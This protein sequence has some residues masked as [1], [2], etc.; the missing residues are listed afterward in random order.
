VCRRALGQEQDAEDAFQTTFLALARSAGSVRRQGAL[1]AWLYGV[2]HR[3]A[4]NAQRSLAR[5]RQKEQQ[6]ARTE[7]SPPPE[8]LSWREVQALLDEEVQA[9]PEIY[10]RVFVLCSLLGQTR[11]EAARQLGL[12][13]GTVASRLGK[14]RALL[15]RRLAR[16]GVSL[17]TLM[18]ALDVAQGA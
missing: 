17:S 18:A 7:A 13:E 9:L 10:R 3:V 1:A 15:R 4:R 5:R 6:A 8:D 11:A 12:K 16:R 2:A 14:A